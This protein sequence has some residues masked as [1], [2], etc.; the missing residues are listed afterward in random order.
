MNEIRDGCRLRDSAKLGQVSADIATTKRISIGDFSRV[1]EKIPWGPRV[2]NLVVVFILIAASVCYTPILYSY[3]Q[4]NAP[5]T[6]SYLY[7][8]PPI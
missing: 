8:F 7:G 2:P 5:L 3:T 4:R 6:A 1:H